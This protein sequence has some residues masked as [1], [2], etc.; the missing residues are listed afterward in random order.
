MPE[1]VLN[2]RWRPPPYIA[3]R[4]PYEPH[5]VPVGGAHEMAVVDEG[6]RDADA[7]VLLHGN[8]AWGFL[9]RHFVPPLL[10]AGFRVVVPDLVGF[11]RSSKPEDPAYHTLEQH[12]RNLGQ[13]LEARGVDGATLVVHDWGGP[14]GLGWA[15][16]HPDRVRRLVIMNTTA[17]P[18]RRKRALSA[19]HALFATRAGPLM[20]RNLNL[21]LESAFRFGVAKP[22][23][24]RGAIRRAYAW[25][26]PTPV[27]RTGPL[28]LVR[29]VPDGP[30]HPTAETLRE[31][32]AGYAEIAQ[33]PAIV[34][35]GDM[36][37]VF[38]PRFAERWRDTLGGVRRVERFPDASH[39]L[40]E[41]AYEDVVPALLRFLRE[42]S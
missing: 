18:P 27:S 12:I 13:A 39:F 42:E 24:V 40:Q 1:A 11:G 28:S 23:R 29:L 21:I 30:E 33:K 5:Y 20:G 19:W 32:D 25:P 41:D 3:E 37:P 38:P 31:I 2:P 8:P 34:L 35:W 14:I 36:D 10:E 7:V 26:F 16:R 22:E 15:T 17:F 4:F 9:Y 6:P